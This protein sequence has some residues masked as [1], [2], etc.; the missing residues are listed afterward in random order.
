MYSFAFSFFLK[1]MSTWP[2]LRLAHDVSFSGR[3]PHCPLRPRPLHALQDSV[4]S[5]VG[6]GTTTTTTQ[7]LNFC[8]R[9][10]TSICDSA[11]VDGYLGVQ[12]FNSKTTL[13]SVSASDCYF[14]LL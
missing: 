2:T 1:N 10:L 9:K 6:W 5:I 11:E 7:S 4:A 13:L 3:L 14:H 12:I 8:E